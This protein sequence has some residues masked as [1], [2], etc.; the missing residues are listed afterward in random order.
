MQEE[1]ADGLSKLAQGDFATRIGETF[2]VSAG[3]ENPAMTLAVA[4][5]R[6]LLDSVE[7]EEEERRPW[8]VIFRGPGEPLLEQRIYEL[9]HPEMGTL[10]LFL[11]PLGPSKDESFLYEAVF[12]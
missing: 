4:E 3:E 9:Q 12:T 11:V 6:A 10:P 2:E 1:H 8:S 5:T 7:F